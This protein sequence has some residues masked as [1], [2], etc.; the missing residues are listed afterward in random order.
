ML[1]SNRFNVFTKHSTNTYVSRD[2]IHLLLPTSKSLEILQRSEFSLTYLDQEDLNP[3]ANIDFDSSLLFRDAHKQV[4]ALRVT[5]CQSVLG[6]KLVSLTMLVDS[7]FPK[8][9]YGDDSRRI[10]FE[11]CAIHMSIYNRYAEQV[12][13]NFGLWGVR[14]KLMLIY[15][16]G[17]RCTP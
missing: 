3:K 1:T 16:K 14:I 5:H 8:E 4:I 7:L 15:S 9:L 17:N 10:G 6:K 13:L 11:F 2:T 12:S